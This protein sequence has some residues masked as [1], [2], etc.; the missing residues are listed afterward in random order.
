MQIVYE[1]KMLPVTNL[2]EMCGL[3]KRFHSYTKNNYTYW[4]S[5]RLYFK[6]EY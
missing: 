5:W 2:A 4:S 3:N 6:F 1:N